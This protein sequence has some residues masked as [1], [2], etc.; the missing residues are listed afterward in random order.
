V[1]L[2]D[3]NLSMESLMVIGAGGAFVLASLLGTSLAGRLLHVCRPNEILIFSGRRRRTST[4]RDVGFRIVTGGRA[5]RMPV[6]ERVDRM[7][8]TLISVPMSVSGAYSEGGIPLNVTAIANVKVSSDPELIGNAIERF[9][10]KS[11]VEIARVSK[12]TLEGHIRGVLASMTPEE[13]N[14]DRLKFAERLSE[15]AGPDLA[16][17]G[18]QLDT[19]KIQQIADDR[20]YLDS[21]G[22]GRIAEILRAAQVAESDAV[23][24]AEKA[25][26]EAEARGQIAKSRA[27][28]N[29]QRRQNEAR[30]LVAELN[31][32]A[33]SEEERTA[34]AA[35]AVRAET[36]QELHRLRAQVEGLRLAADVTVPAQIARRVK[37]L[38]AEG[39]S[40]AIAAKGEAVSQA[41]THLHEA[42]RECG[43]DAMDMVVLQHVDEIFGRA[44][45]A[46]AEVHAK[47]ASLL[48]AGDGQSIASYVGAYPATVKKLLEQV[49]DVFGVSFASV[50]SGDV[51]APSGGAKA[52]GVPERAPSTGGPPPR[53][54][55]PAQSSAPPSVAAE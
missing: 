17:L 25:E 23:R 10:G 55:L 32:E 7:D 47:H 50:L 18:L 51:A 22:R 4:G 44:T 43:E 21:I 34:Q 14:E 48:D 54:E 45:A 38:Y 15:E 29:L 24:M 27:N 42:W 13:V 53:A 16:K 20:S 41:L 39:D 52:G 19:L 5:L 28:A 46:A 40:A 31:A 9:L 26:A 6:L 33:R 37:T 49:S 11:A 1:N 35:A 12:E 3:L 2:T 30:Q 36:E 8:M